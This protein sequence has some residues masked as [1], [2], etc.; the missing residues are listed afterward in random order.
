MEN[1]LFPYSY[2]NMSRSLR[3]PE[4]AMGTWMKNGHFRAISRVNISYI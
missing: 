2:R 3:L 4:I 1:T